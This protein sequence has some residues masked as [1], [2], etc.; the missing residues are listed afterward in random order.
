M[1]FATRP[2]LVLLFSLVFAAI[3]LTA[4]QQKPGNPQLPDP[5]S[6]TQPQ[7]PES[8]QPASPN[9]QKQPAPKPTAPGQV[10]SETKQNFTGRIVKS[11]DQFVLKDRS[12]NNIYQL[13]RQDLA[14]PY[15]G[16]D[17]K[18]AGTLDTS[19]NTIRVFSIEPLS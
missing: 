16:K 12:S 1:R 18:V 9:T 17:V 13:D 19:E 7:R 10:S 15:E 5:N 2:V 4:Q 11:K 3:Q 8:A 14:K 6:E